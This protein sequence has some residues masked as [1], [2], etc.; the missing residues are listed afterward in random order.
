VA[1]VDGSGSVNIKD[2]TAIQKY[3]AKIETG[4]PIGETV[5]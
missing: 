2:A 5:K 4:Y 1:D 3:V